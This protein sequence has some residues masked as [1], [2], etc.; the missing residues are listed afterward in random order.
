[1]DRHDT[2]RRRTAPPADG[3]ATAADLRPALA[4]DLDGTFERLVLEHQ[5]R[6]Y[7]LALRMLGDPRDAEE[8]AQDAFVRAY[9]ALATYD[10]E[11][12]RDLQLRAWLA[13][14]VLNLCRNRFRRASPQLVPLDGSSPQGACAPAATL[15][16]TDP[17][18][19]PHDAALRHESA[20]RWAGLVMTLPPLYRAAVVL[21]HVDGLSYSEIATALGRP[22]GTVK[23]QVHRGLAMLRTAVGR[24]EARN[25]TPEEMTA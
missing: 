4:R 10:E 2:G 14:I 17:L 25:R 19:S 15:A 24:A 8:I 16:T 5:D 9:R 22:E 21:R 13:T 1:M 7:S 3:A 20:R 18:G 11:R 6:L 12:I 23:A